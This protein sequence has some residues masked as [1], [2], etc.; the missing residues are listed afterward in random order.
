MSFRRDLWFAS[1]RC[2]RPVVMQSIVHKCGL[3]YDDDNKDVTSY[4]PDWR[5]A[6]V[7][8]PPNTTYTQTLQNAFVYENQKARQ[9]RCYLLTVIFKPHFLHST[10]LLPQG[11]TSRTAPHFSYSAALLI[12]RRTSHTAPYDSYSAALLALRHTSNLVQHQTTIHRHT[13]VQHHTTVH[14]HTTVQHHT[15]VQRHTTVQHLTTVQHQ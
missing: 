9:G 5:S 8:P 10:T 15:T 12:Q 14:R 1:E 3:D 6:T 4:G 11:H 13:T 2:H 7:A